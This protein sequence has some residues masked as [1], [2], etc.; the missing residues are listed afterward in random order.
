MKAKIL[1]LSIDIQR[2]GQRRQKGQ[3]GRGVRQRGE[4]QRC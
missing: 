3:R 2:G 4:R 1:I